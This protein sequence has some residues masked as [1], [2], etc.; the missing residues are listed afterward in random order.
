V[1]TASSN[2][3][4][5][6]SLLILGA[7]A[8]GLAA[9]FYARRAGLPFQ[10]VE[11]APR[12]GGLAATVEEGPFRFDLGAHRFHDRDPAVTAD[13]KALLGDR[14]VRVSGRS[15]IFWRGRL[16]Q[17]PPSPLNLLTR[18]G[19][20]KLMR[21]G[22]EMLAARRSR[23]P[24]RSFEDTAVRAYGRTLAD[25]LL[26][27][28]TEKLWG[29]PCSQLDR[30][31]GGGRLRGLNLRSL[32]AEAVLGETRRAQHLDG[33]FY[34]P[35]RGMGELME[36]LAGACGRERILT[37]RPVTGIRHAADRIQ[38]VEVEGGRTL[39]A[40]VV[41][42]TLPADRLI[43]LLDPAVPELQ[44]LTRGL[45]FRHL[46]LVTLFVDRPSLT[47]SATL[48]FPDPQVPFT[49]VYE[50]RNR[51]PQ[52]SPEGRTSLVAEI[53]CSDGETLWTAPDDALARL[54]QDHL[55][56]LGWLRPEEI[57]GTRVLRVPR[58]YPVMAVG[59]GVRRTALLE[60]L[61]RFVNLRV[62]G[63]NG[64]FQYTWVHVL[65]GWGRELVDELA[66]ARPMA[67]AKI[68]PGFSFEEALRMTSPSGSASEQ[69][70]G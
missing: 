64:R 37:G 20:L 63:R 22:L 41:V 33:S 32:L 21:S 15:H 24:P 48:Y 17:F 36:A 29:L 4:G 70:S 59:A 28:Y 49:R 25:L 51:S 14:L 40:D 65:M 3:T 47:R 67:Q 39:A 35:A 44:E 38:A 10:V 55:V 26:L 27:R 43:A 50:P 58:A 9:G 56:R 45:R 30:D 1:S 16:L 31:V 42:S 61:D 57:L 66:S 6:P 62:S 13:V 11:A 46:R 19:P 52:M 69:R 7:G 12:V 5:G 23:R 54:V 68:L 2:P 34:Y 8:A 60:R 53:P 18:V